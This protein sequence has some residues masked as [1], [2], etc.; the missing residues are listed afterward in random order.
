M[1]SL[2]SLDLYISLQISYSFS[3]PSNI[4]SSSLGKSDIYSSRVLFTDSSLWALPSNK[5]LTELII[6]VTKPQ[7]STLWLM[8]FCLAMTPLL[9][10]QDGTDWTLNT[11]DK[12]YQNDVNWNEMFITNKN[13]KNPNWAKQLTLLKLSH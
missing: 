7:W 12:C 13:F 4:S 1:F 3:R 9:T 6:F 5:P 11:G 2:I 10:N 8:V